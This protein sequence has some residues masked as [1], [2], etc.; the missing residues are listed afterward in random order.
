MFV[1]ASAIMAILARESDG[2][3]LAGRLDRA[4]R[5]YTSPLAIYETVLAIAR[6]RNISVTDA[7]AVANSFLAAAQI[8]VIPISP[9]IARGA[10]NAF[11]QFG[12]GRHSARL[13]MGD[14]FAY[15]CAR[16]LAVPLLFK[17]D[18]F[19]QTDIAVA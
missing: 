10:I 1:D 19:S 16:A 18:D 12:R 8:E 2:P 5:V 14:C 15:T 13:N 6:I 4:Q 3:A 11:E 17:D 7:E 9:E